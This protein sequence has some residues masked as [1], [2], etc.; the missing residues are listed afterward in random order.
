M[1]HATPRK[2]QDVTVRASTDC[3][4]EKA[5]AVGET[6]ARDRRGLTNPEIGE[7]RKRAGERKAR[8]RLGGES[9]A[10]P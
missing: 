2:V 5:S 3:S 6:A 1:R 9:Y 4:E 10:E 8:I 7:S